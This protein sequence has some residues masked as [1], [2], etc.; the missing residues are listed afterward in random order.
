MISPLLIK[1]ALFRVFSIS[2]KSLKEE[3]K[4]IK[5]SEHGWKGYVKES[6]LDVIKEHKISPTLMKI[7]K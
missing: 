7:K 6:I 4:S 3:I 2:E 5:K 1:T